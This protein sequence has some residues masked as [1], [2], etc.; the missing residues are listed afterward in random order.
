VH[1]VIARVSI[2]GI[3]AGFLLD[4]FAFLFVLIEV[5]A[6]IEDGS[7]YS[8]VLEIQRSIYFVASPVVFP[9]S[10][11]RVRPQTLHPRKCCQWQ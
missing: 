2:F 10:A 4:F 1:G 7:F 3:I 11:G 8:S 9:F 5:K 6:E